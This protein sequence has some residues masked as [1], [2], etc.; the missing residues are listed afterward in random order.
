MLCTINNIVCTL[1]LHTHLPPTYWVE[2]LHM[3]ENILNILSSITLNND[4]PFHKF[5]NKIPTYKHLRIFRY[6]CF[7]NIVTPHKLSP[8][9][10][11]CVF[12]R[13]PSNHKGYRCL[14]L[15]TKKIIVSKHVIFD[16]TISPSDPWYLL[17]LHHI[18]F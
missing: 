17:P 16:E 15:H 11:P 6:L 18:L 3:E 4:I 14:E 1:L 10:T 2:A 13:Y 7:P 12:R 8:R 5:Y 9:S